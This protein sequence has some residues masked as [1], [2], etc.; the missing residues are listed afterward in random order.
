MKRREFCRLVAA[1][2]TAIAAPAIGAEAQQSSE[3]T[4]DAAQSPEFKAMNS[5]TQVR[6]YAEFV[7]LLLARDSFTRLR[8]AGSLK[9]S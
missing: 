3:Q 4:G 9:K 5:P 2:A 1:A 8:M 7:A 6:D